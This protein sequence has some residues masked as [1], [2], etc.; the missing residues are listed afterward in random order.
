MLKGEVEILSAVALKKYNRKQISNSHI[1]RSNQYIISTIDSLL[2]EG[3]IINTQ[4]NGYQLTLKGFETLLENLPNDSIDNYS[5]I[6][7]LW[8]KKILKANEAF[9]LIETLDSETI[10]KLEEL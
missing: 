9:E 6:Y 3:Y 8:D 4:S 10:K 2:R 7:R 5:I 1:A